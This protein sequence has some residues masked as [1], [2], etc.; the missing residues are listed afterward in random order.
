MSLSKADLHRVWLLR[1]LGFSSSVESNSDLE[2][3][4]YAAKEPYV[5]RWT[6]PVG[7][8]GTSMDRR[9]VSSQAIAVGSGRAIWAN[10]WLNAGDVATQLA[11][12]SGTT[13]AVTPTHQWAALY[14]S[15]NKLLGVTEN[16]TTEAWAAATFKKFNLTSP[17]A[18]TKSGLYKV[19][20]V[21]VAATPITLVGTSLIGIINLEGEN[22]ANQLS[23]QANTGLTDTASAPA[24]LSNITTTNT[25]PY[26]QVNGT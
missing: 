20:F 11:F 26:M 24:V 2:N 13:A 12:M 15:D 9:Q 21:I 1:M 18:I 10:V 23:G 7:S 22:A 19:I 6:D 14:D 4:V 8:I 3:Q 16:K 5:R 17:V 25:F